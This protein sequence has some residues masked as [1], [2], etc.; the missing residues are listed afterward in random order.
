M[1]DARTTVI[2]LIDFCSDYLYKMRKGYN[3][4]TILMIPAVG[5]GETGKGSYKTVL[6]EIINNLAI[7]HYSLPDK[8]ILSLRGYSI[9]KSEYDAENIL[10][11]AKRIFE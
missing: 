8:T 4:E 10:Q 9:L 5:T 3:I 6:I 1:E 7:P 11:L 2:R